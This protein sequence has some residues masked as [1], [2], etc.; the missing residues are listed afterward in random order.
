MSEDAG[1]RKA[2]DVG[3]GHAPRIVEP[4]GETRQ[5]RPEN[6]TDDGLLGADVC[7][8]RSRRI[9]GS[10]PSPRTGHGSGHDLPPRSAAMSAFARATSVARSSAGRNALS[11]PLSAIVLSSSN[12]KSR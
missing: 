8:D 1:P 2:G 9:R 7:A 5:S 6:Q 3:V 10:A 11:K 12:E 4:V